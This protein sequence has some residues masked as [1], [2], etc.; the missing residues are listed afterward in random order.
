MISHAAMLLVTALLVAAT[1]GG[2]TPTSET[3]QRPSLSFSAATVAD[4]LFE[5]ESGPQLGDRGL[6]GA[7]DR[8]AGR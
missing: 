3:R 2:A 8:G 6:D 4:G 5:I 1:P 7:L